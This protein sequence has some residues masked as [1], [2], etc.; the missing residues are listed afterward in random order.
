MYSQFGQKWAK[1]HHGQCGVLYF[2]SNSV[3]HLHNTETM[4]VRALWIAFI[5]SS[6]ILSNFILEALV[7]IPSIFESTHRRD[8]AASGISLDAQI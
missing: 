2:S 5:V 3:Q 6:S 8:I 1:L 4:H 7:N